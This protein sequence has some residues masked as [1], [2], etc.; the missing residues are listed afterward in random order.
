MD[1][2]GYSGVLCGSCESGYGRMGHGECTKCNE[3]KD[4]SIAVISTIA[5][6]AL[7][8]VSIGIKSALNTTRDLQD[9][10]AVAAHRTMNADGE[11]RE[12][13]R[14]QMCLSLKNCVDDYVSDAKGSCV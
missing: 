2:Q 7:I 14:H 13:R 8:L 3:D 11:K 10:Q 5:L 4:E 1:K 9:M 6:W 12:A